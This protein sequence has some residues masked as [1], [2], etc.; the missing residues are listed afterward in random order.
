MQQQEPKKVP[1]PSERLGIMMDK[2][3][4]PEYAIEASRLDTYKAWPK[5]SVIMPTELAKAGFFYIG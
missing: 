4:H 5:R 2:P 1:S 3:K